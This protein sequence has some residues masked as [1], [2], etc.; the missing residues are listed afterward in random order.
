MIYLV[1]FAI[2]VFFSYIVEQKI[3]RKKRIALFS[4]L[5]VVGPVLLAWLRS[6]PVGIDVMLYVEPAFK[7]A[8]YCDGL[9]YYLSRI[10]ENEDLGFFT[11]VYGI[12]KVFGEF[13][14]VLFFCH[15]IIVSLC[16]YS[17][18]F[19]KQRYNCSLWF[20][21]A[22][23]LLHF[24]NPSLCLVRQ[25]LA[26]ALF[27]AGMT[28]L[29]QKKYIKCIIMFILALSVH[30]TM[31]A[32]VVACVLLKIIVEHIESM[33]L[34]I[35]LV[36][37]MFSSVLFASSLAG[38]AINI[39][40]AKYAERLST[41]EA[42][43]GGIVTIVTYAL[44]AVIPFIVCYKNKNIQLMFFLYLPV[45]GFLFQSMG[46]LTMYF[47]RMGIPFMAMIMFTIPYVM[48]NKKYQKL[49][50]LFLLF[51]WIRNIYFGRHWETVPY[52]ISPELF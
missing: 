10:G 51:L 33:K 35:F 9:S 38:F 32:V 17:L 47:I 24:Y 40:D 2:S 22:I 30:K 45:L 13:S 44:L 16:F 11:M 36:L 5:A 41:L 43:S 19:F 48:K 15:L 14:V 27:L 23:M 8:K 6:N 46:K 50:L 12:T 4:G 21:Y 20:G 28:M 26:F 29:I 52:I 18:V 31:L 34:K 39:V 49:F 1:V 37:L 42:N 3:E 25:G 7:L